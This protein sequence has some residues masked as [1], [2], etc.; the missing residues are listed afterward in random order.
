MSEKKECC[1]SCTHYHWYYD[2][3]DKWDCEV[4]SRAVNDCFEPRR[5]KNEGSYQPAGGN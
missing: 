2:Y 1:D 3:C 5:N 4:D